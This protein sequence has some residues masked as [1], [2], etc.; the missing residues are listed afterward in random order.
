[1]K[2]TIMEDRTRII[3]LAVFL[4]FFLGQWLP[5]FPNG[6][7]ENISLARYLAFPT[8]HT[9]VTEAIE[10]QLADYN[11]NGILVSSIFLPLI[12]I[13][14]L[15]L[16]MKFGTNIALDIASAIWAI[17]GLIGFGGNPALSLGGATQSLYLLLFVI[18]LVVSL[19]NIASIR[20]GNGE[21]GTLKDIGAGAKRKK[22]V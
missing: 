1:M 11:I 9:G 4:L 3:L 5:Y 12:G 15:V 22:A 19:L 7:G 10:A 13:A 18:A 14:L 2:K 16:M 17:F 6:N 8:N 20:K 21:I